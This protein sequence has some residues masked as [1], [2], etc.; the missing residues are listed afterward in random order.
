MRSCAAP[1]AVPR[2][3]PAQCPPA[4]GKAWLLVAEGRARQRR[5]AE[6]AERLL[7]NMLRASG[8]HQHPRVH[9]VHRWSWPV[10]LRWRWRGRSVGRCGGAACA[11]RGAGDGPR[12]RAVPGPQRAVGAVARPVFTLAGVPAVVTFR[13]AGA[14]A[15]PASSLRPGKTLPRA[16][17]AAAAAKLSHAHRNK[18][19]AIIRRLQF[20]ALCHEAYPSR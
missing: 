12:R 20:G 16:W 10:D 15:F 4:L 2:C 19:G 17:L 3:R 7:D 9:F 6:Q 14:A 11:S 1:H 18:A 5:L 8:L 13:C